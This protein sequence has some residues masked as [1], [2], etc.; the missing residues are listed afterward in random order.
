MEGEWMVINNLFK[1]LSLHQ[2]GNLAWAQ[3]FWY[4]R[5]DS[6]LEEINMDLLKLVI[7]EKKIA[8]DL[9]SQLPV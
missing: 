6:N 3:R 4:K 1:A 5:H 7:C 9:L 2:W 8:F